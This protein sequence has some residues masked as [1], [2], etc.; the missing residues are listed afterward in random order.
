MLFFQKNFPY[1]FS[2]VCVVNL[3]C[4]ARTVLVYR[5][6]RLFLGLLHYAFF[7]KNTSLFSVAKLLIINFPKMVKISIKNGQ[8]LHGK[9]KIENTAVDFG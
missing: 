7:H 5:N 3:R 8:N 6:S 4:D 2:F 9:L 1:S